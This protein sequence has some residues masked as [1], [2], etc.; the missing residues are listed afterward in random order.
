MRLL[1]RLLYAIGFSSLMM[2]APSQAASVTVSAGQALDIRYTLPGGP[3]SPDYARDTA[4]LQLT[5]AVT[6]ATGGLVASLYADAVH[7]GDDVASPENMFI[8]TASGSL[9]TNDGAT[10]A[11]TTA[12]AGSVTVGRV[13]VRS[14]AGDA[15]SFDDQHVYLNFGEAVFKALRV[16]GGSQATF[17]VA[18]SPVP[19]PAEGMLWA[20]G[21]LTLMGAAT[22]RRRRQECQV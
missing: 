15:W 17:S 11:D 21:L 10:Y 12:I 2:H 3:F 8:W 7:L 18:V 6:G 4:W 5:D 16:D 19:E 14:L 20:F 9:N 1:C 22:H 13:V